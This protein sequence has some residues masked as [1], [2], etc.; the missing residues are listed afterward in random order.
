MTAILRR[1]HRLTFAALAALAGTLCAA[2]LQP[3]YLLLPNTG[4]NSLLEINPS[5]GEVMDTIPLPAGYAF[6]INGIIQLNT[7]LVRADGT[8]FTNALDSNANPVLLALSS[9]GTL[10]A[11]QDSGGQY[12]QQLAFDPSDRTESTIL[13]GIPFSPEIVAINPFAHTVTPRVTLNGANF[14]GLTT[15]ASGYLYCGDYGDGIVYQ[16]HSDGT[17]PVTYVNVGQTTGSGEID[18]IAL[19]GSSLFVAQNSSQRIAVFDNQVYSGTIS[20]SQF[21]HPSTVFY[22]PANS[23]LYVG[24][25]DDGYL[26]VLTTAGA[27]VY[28]VD[29]GGS[30]IGEAGLVPAP[31]EVSITVSV[32]GNTLGCPGNGFPVF[33]WLAN[34]TTVGRFGP[35]LKLN[36]QFDA[37][38]PSL[39]QLVARGEHL[40]SMELTETDADPAG[41]EFVLTMSSVTAVAYR[42]F[43]SSTQGAP[44]EEVDFDFQKFQTSG[45]NPPPT[46]GASPL[47]SGGQST[48]TVTGFGCPSFN[49][50]AWTFQY[51]D[52]ATS[53]PSRLA[54]IQMPAGSC[55]SAQTGQ[56]FS[57]V[58][59]TTQVTGTNTGPLL[60]LTLSGVM[61]TQES[62]SG[63]QE[64]WQLTYTQAQE[65]DLLSQ[66]R[67]R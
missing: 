14:I 39:L 55:S 21:N 26:T 44:D 3:G 60:T 63:A 59:L 45:V 32:P 19:T 9:D 33:E 25:Q 62:T 57:T 6:S 12:L 47:G 13:G 56:H 5:N 36:K 54:Q 65:V 66:N 4:L 30:G 53:S 48:T 34:Y 31:E 41:Q 58:T 18:G 42:L 1:P 27:Q 61:I 52:T 64:Q 17:S 24:N 37:C 23:Y 7:A 11:S 16:Y 20:N 49:A 28:T 2:S 67:G 40:P 35:Y 10:V 50:L 51:T 22:N 8:I 15:D 29:L 46:S 43:E 38:S